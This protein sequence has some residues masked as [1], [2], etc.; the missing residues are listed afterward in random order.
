MH[1]TY[2]GPEKYAPK[3]RLSIMNHDCLAL[4]CSASG[5]PAEITTSLEA[6]FK[7]AD[8]WAWV[9]PIFWNQLKHV[10]SRN[11]QCRSGAFGGPFPNP[12]ARHRWQS[13]NLIS[14][15]ATQ[16]LN[17]TKAGTP[18]PVRSD[19]EELDPTMLT[20]LTKAVQRIYIYIFLGVRERMSEG[21]TSP[22]VGLELQ[23]S[24][25]VCE[26]GL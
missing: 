26:S 22:A 17:A 25:S 3:L 18:R 10:E 14:A 20:M 19:Q 11:S 15:T 6:L 9:P 24:F 5:L 13:Q 4:E 12:F 1:G 23:G 8:Q 7:S 16:R 21:A 2:F